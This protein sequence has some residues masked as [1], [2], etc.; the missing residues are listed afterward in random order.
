MVVY[1]VSEICDYSYW[2]RKIESIWTT[3]EDA[4]NHK[5]KLEDDREVKYGVLANQYRYVINSYTVNGTDVMK[6]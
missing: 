2:F 6:G 1:I 5:N 4:E 3:Y